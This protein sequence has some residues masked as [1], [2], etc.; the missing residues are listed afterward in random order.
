MALEQKVFAFV[1]QTEELEADLLAQI[2]Q[3]E[4]SRGIA[5]ADYRASDNSLVLMASNC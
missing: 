3:L 1:Q 4:A 5:D 2:A